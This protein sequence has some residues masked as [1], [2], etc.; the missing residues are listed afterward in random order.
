MRLSKNPPQS[1]KNYSEIKASKFPIISRVN[2]RVGAGVLMVLSSVAGTSCGGRAMETTILYNNKDDAGSKNNDGNN[3]EGTLPDGGDIKGTPLEEAGVTIIDKG[4]S[5]V[6]VCPDPKVSLYAGP[7][8]P[9][10]NFYTWDRRWFRVDPSTNEIIKVCE[11][12]NPDFCEEGE[13]PEDDGCDAP[14]CD[15][16]QEA[17][18]DP[19]PSRVPDGPT[20]RPDQAN[21]PTKHIRSD[22]IKYI[23]ED[24]VGY[25]V[26][27][28][29][30]PDCGPN[31]EPKEGETYYSCDL[32]PT[33]EKTIDYCDPLPRCK[34]G[35]SPIVC[36]DVP[37]A[38]YPSE[39]TCYD[40][41]YE[42]LYGVGHYGID[43]G[44]WFSDLTCF[45]RTDENTGKT[46]YPLPTVEVVCRVEP[47]CEEGEMPHIITR[48]TPL[49]CGKWGFH[50]S[51]TKR[52]GS[53]DPIKSC[54]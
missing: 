9:N 24:T 25:P 26:I 20:R 5:N 32:I 30:V 54:D 13:N 31:G 21:F 19:I 28:D 48:E 34:E 15:G 37:K 33:C 27:F 46:V 41:L 39:E 14:V 6:P 51:I 22:I 4:C 50:T 23:R 7:H 1:G 43:T 35:Q 52:S 45:P 49:D 12:V 44:M 10:E 42:S 53:C 18:C 40:N 3:I 2:N 47:E 11:P 17:M 29:N 16:V 8:E 36:T 38:E